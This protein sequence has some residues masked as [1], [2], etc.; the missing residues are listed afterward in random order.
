MPNY[1]NFPNMSNQMSSFAEFVSTYDFSQHSLVQ[2]I[3]LKHVFAEA[4]TPIIDRK[5]EALRKARLAKPMFINKFAEKKA[6]APKVSEEALL[7]SKIARL[8]AEI[9]KLEKK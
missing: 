1:P 3:E 7:R 6:K 4:I 2:L 8:E 9:A 5:Q